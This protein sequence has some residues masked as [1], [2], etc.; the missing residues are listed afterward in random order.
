MKGL[1]QFLTPK[2][3]KCGCSINHLIP[4]QQIMRLRSDQ[5]NWK[6]LIQN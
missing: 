1:T 5:K 6:H 4:F 2:K 3:V